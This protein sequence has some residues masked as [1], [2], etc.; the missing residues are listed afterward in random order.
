MFVSIS[1]RLWRSLTKDYYTKV[2]GHGHRIWITTTCVARIFQLTWELGHKYDGETVC[3]L[4]KHVEPAIIQAIGSGTIPTIAV[5]IGRTIK[6]LT[7]FTNDNRCDET[8]TI[9]TKKC[10][11]LLN[12]EFVDLSDVISQSSDLA[13]IQSATPIVP[14][15]LVPVWAVHN[16]R[17]MIPTNMF[18]MIQPRQW[19]LWAF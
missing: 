5:S 4:L 1:S 3:W 13:P 10:K 11:R 18:W 19:A 6:I 17:M 9:T 16:T 7:L 14:Q 2:E 15:R 12:S 8:T